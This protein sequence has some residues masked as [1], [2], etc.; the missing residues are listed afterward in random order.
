MG[1]D[2]LGVF[3]LSL[4]AVVAIILVA[5]PREKA[6]EPPARKHEPRPP[7]VLDEEDFGLGVCVGDNMRKRPQSPYSFRRS[8]AVAKL[9]AH[10]GAPVVSYLFGDSLAVSYAYSEALDT[11]TAIVVSAWPGENAE[12]MKAVKPEA[13][14]KHQMSAASKAHK[15]FPAIATK[16]GIGLGS[17][18]DEVRTAYGTPSK[19]TKHGW[20]IYQEGS[21]Q[22]IFGCGTGR[23][24]MMS[25]GTSGYL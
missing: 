8:E 3:A 15:A 19:T 2:A 11:I 9:M 17:T 22:L 12:Y 10:P 6:P 18:T 24:L 13:Y 14:A 23:V 21:F 25:L 7:L 1:L 5:C 20:L 4:S 16:R